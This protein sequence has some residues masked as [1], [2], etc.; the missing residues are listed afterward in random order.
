[1]NRT[2][3][4]NLRCVAEVVGDGRTATGL[5]PITRQLWET[6][7]QEQ[8]DR[9]MSEAREQF[10]QAVQRQLGYE[11]LDEDVALVPVTL[12]E[13]PVQIGSVRQA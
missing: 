9:F 2:D 10:R 11:L 8:R 12:E 6:A 5:V 7:D 3:T 13:E 4:I 1:M